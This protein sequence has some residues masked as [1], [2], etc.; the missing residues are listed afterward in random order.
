MKWSFLTL[1]ICINILSNAQNTNRSTAGIFIGYSPEN[2]LTIAI[3]S[4]DI[5]SKKTNKPVVGFA[6]LY[7]FKPRFNFGVIASYHQ[8]PYEI[9]TNSLLIEK[10]NFN[11]KY[12]GLI[13]KYNWLKKNQY[14][15]SSGLGVGYNY[16]KKK[17]QKFV[18]GESQV[19]N[20]YFTKLKFS[21]L[22]FEAEYNIVEH[23]SLFGNFN[24][25]APSFIRIGTTYKW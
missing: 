8:V 3:D 22:L 15:L 12:L 9:D 23:F 19:S 6:Y 24:L 4:Q 2:E 1:F 5:F 25:G 13:G 21:I 7:Q 20:E 14:S 18:N 11:V 17:A 10:G 16:T